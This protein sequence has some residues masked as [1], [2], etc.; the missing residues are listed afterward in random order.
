MFSFCENQ[1]SFPSFWICLCQV[2]VLTPA[3]QSLNFLSIHLV[4]LDRLRPV[5]KKVESPVTDIIEEI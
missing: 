3:N 1:S 4:D 2:V 5:K